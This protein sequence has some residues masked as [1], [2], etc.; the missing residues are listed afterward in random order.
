MLRLVDQPR[1]ILWRVGGLFSDYYR[2]QWDSRNLPDWQRIAA[3][4]ACFVPGLPFLYIHAPKA[5]SSSVRTLLS[6][7]VRAKLGPDAFVRSNPRHWREVVPMLSDPQVYRFGVV[8]HPVT[9]AIATFNDFFVTRRHRYGRRHWP[10]TVRFGVHFGDASSE[11]FSR[12]LRYV[13]DAMGQSAQ[14]CDPH[15]RLQ[16][17]NLLLGEI[18]YARLGKAEQLERDLPEIFEAIGLGG[19][20]TAE[21]L[22]DEKRATLRPQPFNTPTAEQLRSIERLYAED[23]EWL[24]YDSPSQ[25]AR[26][27]AAS[28]AK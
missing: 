14:F 15:M 6:T 17:R 13:G 7:V 9:R 24:G 12:Y 3:R 4:R 23:F 2:A 10:Q 22:A 25:R 19:V 21:M 27:R 26:S 11:N 8:L 20:L 16:S 28:S 18:S 1:P 5:A